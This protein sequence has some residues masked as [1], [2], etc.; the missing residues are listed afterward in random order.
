MK[1]LS[2]IGISLCA[3]LACSAGA[4]AH[5][6]GI[7]YDHGNQLTV[8]GT[9]KEFQWTNP[10]T[11]I[12]VM[13]PDG[14]GG[15]EKWDLE[16]TS[17]NTLVRSGWTIK[18]LQAGMKVKILVSPRKDGTPG[19]EFNKIIAINDVPFTPPVAK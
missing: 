9:V 5:H 2:R 10:H 3:V 16:G 17:I 11:W 1:S 15:E 8:T 13:V 18:T 4:Y 14:N 12:I 19:G 6:A 7:A